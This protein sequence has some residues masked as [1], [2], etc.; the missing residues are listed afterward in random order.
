MLAFLLRAD[1]PF[2]SATTKESA[3]A[4]CVLLANAELMSR[5]WFSEEKAHE[6]FV[7]SI[8]GQ[9]GGGDARQRGSS[10]V[11]DKVMGIMT[12]LKKPTPV[13]PEPVPVSSA[14]GDGGD[15]ATI[16]LSGNAGTGSAAG[17]GTGSGQTSGNST[18]SGARELLASITGA[19]TGASSPPPS[20]SQGNGLMLAASSEGPTQTSVAIHPSSAPLYNS[21][22]SSAAA[23][24]DEVSSFVLS[25][26]LPWLEALVNSL[27][28]VQSHLVL[29][30]CFRAAAE[31]TA[32]P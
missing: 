24:T 21:G 31:R 17:D 22:D 6:A 11:V 14:G 15:G 30:L 2:S 27:A 13:E 29:S 16:D 3:Q 25:R 26:G 4:S 20:A 1:P 18:A 10:A 28:C 23:G 19:L 7:A 8:S 12:D 5:G 9:E 32:P